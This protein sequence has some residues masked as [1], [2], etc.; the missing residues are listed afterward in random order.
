MNN[1]GKN[2]SK[3]SNK[4]HY[5]YLISMY[6]LAICL[7]MLEF[8]QPAQAAP[9]EDTTPTNN[10]EETKVEGSIPAFGTKGEKHWYV[11]TAAAIDIDENDAT[12]FGL[13]GGGVSQFFANGHS[14]NANLN[15]LYF[16]QSGDDA[17]GLNLDLLLRYHFLR[18]AN[19]SLFF[20]GG[21]GIIGTTNNVP[22]GGSSFNF[23]PQ[24]AVGS[25]IRVAP[26]KHLMLGLRWHHISNADTF[27]SN[28][29]LDSIMGQ[30][31]LILPR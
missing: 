22:S 24:F 19:W 20:D 11:Q 16:Q 1:Q 10:P 7:V 6:L 27:D 30:V 4:L 2:T 18:R 9:Q 12:S 31:G 8:L 23:T 29:G 15:S 28:P 3:I 21:V 17:L 26:E 25:T 13:I 5:S 14:I